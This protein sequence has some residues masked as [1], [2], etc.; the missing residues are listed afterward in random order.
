MAERLALIVSAGLA[1]AGG[2]AAQTGFFEDFDSFTADVDFSF[3]S[4]SEPAGFNVTHTGDN[5]FRNLIDVSPFNFNDADNG[6]PALS[7]FVDGD[8]ANEVAFTPD[9]P[10][11]SFGFEVTHRSTGSGATITALGASGGII[12]ASPLPIGPSF[13][14]F[15]GFQGTLTNPI[16]ELRIT[17]FV[18]GTSA[19][20]GFNVDNV[21][22]TFIPTPASA[23]LLG[24]A[25]LAACR[26][27]RYT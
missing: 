8:G 24:V 19:G 12:A 25:G 7:L 15:V 23:W 26:H 22:G 21:R 4:T 13:N 11:L 14:E 18:D 20:E 16:V 1:A 3:G 5:D 2:A 17:G 10:L 6:T 9:A 27:R